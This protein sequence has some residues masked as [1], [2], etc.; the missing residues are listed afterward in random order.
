[1]SD[2]GLSVETEVS[3]AIV[4]RLL[5]DGVVGDQTSVKLS[6]QRGSDGLHA[7][8]VVTH[9][10]LV[11][12]TL[13]RGGGNTPQLLTEFP[14][15]FLCKIMWLTHPLASTASYCVAKHNGRFLVSSPAHPTV[16][17]TYTNTQFT[18]QALDLCA[19]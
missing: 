8:N 7:G 9:T 12:L 13:H 18:Q 4:E 11:R 2:G 15:F 3:E 14:P 10:N 6:P 19:V 1:M 5:L 17:R 16:G